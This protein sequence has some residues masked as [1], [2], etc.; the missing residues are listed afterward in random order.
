MI[1]S[2]LTKVLMLTAIF[3][4]CLS[5]HLITEYTYTDSHTHVAICESSSRHAGVVYRTGHVPCRHTKVGRDCTLDLRSIVVDR[6]IVKNL[7][8]RIVMVRSD[9]HHIHGYGHRISCHRI[10]VV[11]DHVSD[12]CPASV[13]QST[14][15][16]WEFLLVSLY[17]SFHI[18]GRARRAFSTLMVRPYLSSPDRPVLAA[19]AS[20]AV[21]METKPKP[22]DSFVCGSVMI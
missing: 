20:S 19:S 10:D 12:H 1:V 9:H 3:E 16:E 21:I 4:A 18:L 2:F 6:R 13:G 22:R 15:L 5:C 14:Y 8:R 11:V 17:R 7:G